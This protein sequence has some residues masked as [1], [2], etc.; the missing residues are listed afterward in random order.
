MFKLVIRIVLIFLGVIILT[1]LRYRFFKNTNTRVDTTKTVYITKND[2][3]FNLIRNDEKFYIKGA[4]GN[5]YLK[6]LSKIGGNTIRVYD[7]E[8]LQTILDSAAVNSLAV[9]VDIYLPKY[10]KETNFYAI[11]ENRKELRR[12]VKVLVNKY[13]NHPALLLWNL[14]N[15]VDYPRVVR[16]NS[17]INT[18]NNLIDLIH[19]IDPNHPISTSITK[20]EIFSILFHSP[21]LDL[22]GFNTFGNL[23][24]LQSVI[25]TATFLIKP[26]PH[27][28]SEYANNGPW[29]E[30]TTAWSVPIEQTSIKKAEQ[31]RDQYEAYIKTDKKSL[32]SLVFY[33]GYKQEYTHTWFSIFDKKGRKS[34]VYYALESSWNNKAFINPS[35]ASIKYILIDNKGANKNLIFKP[36]ETKNA[37][38]L[39]ENKLNS[40]YTYKWSVYKEKWHK[41]NSTIHTD[42]PI[43]QQLDNVSNTNKCKFTF[44]TPTS[45]GPYRLFIDLYDDQGNFSTSNVPFYVLSDNE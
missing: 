20:K 15:E 24:D 22:Y 2:S 42:K 8:N 45:D 18:F 17:F 31:Y 29:E 12:N 43:L 33:W 19:N 28:L 13:K 27:Y 34:P 44:T 39:L 5:K 16:K 10:K 6:E 26:F 1:F 14:G 41:N 25:N 23:K 11:E 35:K 21:K 37:T 36:N 9:I 7:T 38:I 32:G 4:S 3:T 30:Q 40:N